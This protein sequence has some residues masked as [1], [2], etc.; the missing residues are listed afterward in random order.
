M[1]RILDKINKLNRYLF[2]K[3]PNRKKIRNKDVTII[4]SNCIGG[5]IYNDCGLKFNSMTINLFF[6]AEDFIKFVEKLEYYLNL[7]LVEIK[8]DNYNY[9]IGMLGDLKIHFV[10]YKSFDEAKNKWDIRKK[11]VNYE[12]I[13]I[14]MTDRDGCNNQLVNRFHRLPYN[15]VLFSCKK[16][17]EYEDVIFMSEFEGLE[18]VG[19]ITNFYSIFG[20]RIYDKYFNYVDYINKMSV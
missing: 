12:N 7:E 3:L 20:K 2:V 15:K 19:N 4:S 18:Q 13:L 6:E 14:I 5:L 11:R 10:H 8:L 16:Y 17:N 9:P 1:K